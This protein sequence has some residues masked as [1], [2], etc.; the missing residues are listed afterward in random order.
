MQS[1]EDGLSALPQKIAELGSRIE[2]LSKNK[3]NA[4]QA[5]AQLASLDSMLKDIEERTE[6]MQ[7]AREWL[8]RTETRLEEI[9]RQA[10]D[11]VKLLGS[12][13]K[14]ETKTAGKKGT[15]KGAPSMST[16]DMVTRLAHQG[17]KVPQIAQAT[18][19]SRGE[20]ELILELLPKTTS[21]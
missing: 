19:L 1:V 7:S 5:I 14:E 10:E 15:E 21:K 3:K 2:T 20:V 8:A 4:D 11:Q 12:L 17:W 6:K 18:K 13:L 9:G 16:R